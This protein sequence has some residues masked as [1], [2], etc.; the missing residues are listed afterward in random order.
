MRNLWALIAGAVLIMLGMVALI[1]NLMGVNLW[2]Y[3]CPLLL[4]AAGAF[5]LLRPFLG[6][7]LSHQRIQLIG[8]VRLKGEW[9]PSDEEMWVGVADVDIDFT[10]ARLVEGETTIRVYGGVGDIEVVVPADVGVSVWCGGFVTN[11]MFFGGKQESILAP[12]RS[13]SE[14]YAEASRRVRLELG[15]FVA[16]VTVKEGQS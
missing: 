12:I 3:F 5:L 11:V 6:E 1:N 15:L 2:A 9:S 10:H 7:A 8:D 16:D 4:I 13:Q 14:G